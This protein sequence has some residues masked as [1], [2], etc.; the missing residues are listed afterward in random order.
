MIADKEK[1]SSTYNELKLD[2]LPDAKIHKIKKHAHEYMEKLMRKIEK[3]S[4]R[5]RTHSSST[6]RESSSSTILTASSSTM[7]ETPD[8]DDESGDGKFAEMTVEE[9]MDMDM[10]VDDGEDVDMGEDSQSEDEDDI[11]ASPYKVNGSNSLNPE[12][13]EIQEDPDGDAGSL[14]N[15]AMAKSTDP[16]RRLIEESAPMG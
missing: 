15:L 8:A 9:A 1:K 14:T 4:H 10:D 2:A 16:R 6:I 12:A 7:V 5:K 13:M 3:S 11:P